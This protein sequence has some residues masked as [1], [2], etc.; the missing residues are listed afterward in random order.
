MSTLEQ[1]LKML[2]RYKINGTFQT[3]QKGSLS[4]IFCPKL[5]PKK[6]RNFG[7]YIFT[8]KNSETD[9]EE[10]VYIGKNGTLNNDGFFGNHTLNKRIMQGKIK[11]KWLVN[12]NFKV[13]WFI[14]ILRSEVDIIP[15]DIPTVV[16]CDLLKK[17]FELEKKLPKNNNNFWLIIIIKI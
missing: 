11:S 12:N 7:V 9:V 8:E 15:N 16:E 10:I 5:I 3:N 6:L 17:F 4:K 1:L 14:T 13:Y 2:S